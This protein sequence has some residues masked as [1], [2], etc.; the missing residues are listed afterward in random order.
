MARSLGL[1]LGGLLALPG[2][3]LAKEPA[4]AAP[5]KQATAVPARLTLRH[6]GERQQ[7]LV[8][9]TLADGSVR[10]LTR[11][12]KYVSG[13]SAVAGVDAGGVVTPRGPGQTRIEISAPGVS[14][15][16]EVTVAG[17]GRPAVSFAND[18]MPLLAKAGCNS[19]ACHGAASGKKGFK[20]SLRGYDP[21]NDFITLTRGTEARRINFIDPDNSLLLLKPTGRVPHEGGQRFAADSDQARLLR[22]WIAEGATSDLGR[23]PTLVGLDVAP[24]FRTFHQPGLGQQL[25]VTARLSDGTSR[26][27]TRDA[28]Y[29]T[30]N[31]TAAVPDEAGLVTMPAK[32]EA[33]IMVRYGPLVA[34]STLV[35]LKHDPSFAWTNPPENNYIDRLVNA[36]LRH[37]EILPSDLTTD[38]EFLRRVHYDLLGLPPTAAEVR[39]FLADKRAD[40]R[41]RVIDALLER[42]EHAEF[43]AL[44]WGDL[45]K[46]RSDLLTDRGAWGMYRWLRDSVAGNKPFDRFVRE[47]IAADGS[48][49]KNPPANYWRV[50]TNATDAGEATAQ[51]FLGIR[52]MCAKCHDHPF[53]KWVQKDYNGFAGFFGQVSR[54]TGRRPQDQVIFRTEAAAQVKFLDGAAVAVTGQQDARQLLAGWL[55]RKDNP[56][57][58]RATV[59]RLWSYL[60][61]KGIIDP[62]DDIRSSNPPVN[63]PLLD[64]LTKD[65]LDHDFDVRHVLRTML[66]SRTYQL[67]ARVNK[68]NADDRQNFS[69]ALP[70][71]LS[72]E[73]LLDTISLATGIRANFRARY[74]GAGTVSLPVGGLRAGQLPDRQL[75]AEMLEL[76]GRPKGES[77]CACERHE[78][79]SMTQA[80]HLINGQG[81]NRRL[82]DPG[83][84]VARL[85]KTPKITDKQII[86]ELYLTV[87]CR[88]PE[89][90]ETALWEKHFAE[91]KDRLKAGQDLMWVLFNTKEFLF[92]H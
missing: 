87:V 83:G 33:A 12:V 40:K 91:A 51:I 52:L 57:L 86:E 5:V 77:T 88:P 38:T 67:S 73:Q 43:W 55:T 36:K 63:G 30:N 42:P 9:A 44:K 4:P 70:R 29:S 69:H 59:N 10:D 80:L 23:A 60:F 53:E 61:G 47:I 16:V 89:A 37:M 62:V 79:A 76:F 3:G 39:A 28:R 19:G 24:K 1:L 81:V 14:L 26:D 20:V 85:V 71:R 7:L 48:C 18:V 68:F 25:Q 32:G 31:E 78:E 22:R 84:R 46:L 56:F 34:V 45:L 17:G 90:A 8:S 64:A 74:V 27:V 54:K 82:A 75:T 21:A 11:A 49:A 41:A 13:N 15:G 65:F 72:A 2:F 35:V 6:A 50:F 92:N 66:N 58:A